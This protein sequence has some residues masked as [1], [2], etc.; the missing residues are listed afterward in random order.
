MT[1]EALQILAK[2]CHKV[3]LP[4]R[5]HHEECHV[6]RRGKHTASRLLP[7]RKA[8]AQAPAQNWPRFQ[9][10]YDA[11]QQEWGLG[12]FKRMICL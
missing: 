10:I 9:L 6:P 3:V 2:V 7:S 12:S 11:S 8:P 4:W 5:R 1:R